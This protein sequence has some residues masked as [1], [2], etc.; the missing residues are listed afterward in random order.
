[1]TT[2][3]RS[4][5][6]RYDRGS[7]D[8]RPYLSGISAMAVNFSRDPNWVTYVANPAPTLWRSKVDGSERLQLTFTPLLTFM[9]RWSPDATRIAFIAHQ[10]GDRRR[11]DVIAGD[12]G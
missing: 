2:Q 12:G 8:F 9:P 11:A 10:P 7:D 6:V 3:T 4:E 1:M 5:L